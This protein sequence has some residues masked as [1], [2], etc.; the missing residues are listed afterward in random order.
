MEKVSKMN[1]LNG[2]DYRRLIALARRALIRARIARQEEVVH[3]TY[4]EVMGYNKLA[5][6]L[7]IS[8]KQDAKEARAEAK[9]IL[10]HIEITNG[11]RYLLSLPHWP[12]KHNL[13]GCA[14]RVWPQYIE[15]Y[16]TSEMFKGV[17]PD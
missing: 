14:F 8:C 4:I 9:G 6:Y 17:D 13:W 16:S 1:N 3:R 12:L 7:A 10:K 11:K 5:H 2:Q 15:E